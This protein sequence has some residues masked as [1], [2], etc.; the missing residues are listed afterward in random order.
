MCLSCLPTSVG[1][2]IRID[3]SNHMLYLEATHHI[4]LLIYNK[5]RMQSREAMENLKIKADIEDEAPGQMT[6]Q[7]V[8][9]RYNDGLTTKRTS[10]VLHIE[11]KCISAREWRCIHT[12]TCT[13]TYRH[14]YIHACIHIT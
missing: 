7:L 9:E 6:N 1:L 10:P 12:H 13:H 3:I 8:N 4:Q 14:T 2:R 5:H 11:Y